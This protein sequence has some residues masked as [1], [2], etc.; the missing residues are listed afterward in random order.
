MWGSDYPHPEGTWPQ[1]RDMMVETFHGLPMDE[2]ATMLGG[3]AADF[4]SIDREKL[5]PLVAEIGPQSS[6]FS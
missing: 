6:L 5:A 3:S 1:T 4:Y 2:I